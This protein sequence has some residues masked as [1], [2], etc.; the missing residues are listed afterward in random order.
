MAFAAVNLEI[1]SGTFSLVLEQVLLW[2][3]Y[4]LG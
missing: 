4:F 2:V 1:Q 3:Y